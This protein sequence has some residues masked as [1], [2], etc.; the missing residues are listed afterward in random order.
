MDSATAADYSAATPDPV[1]PHAA[2]AIAH[3]NADHADSLA[4]M[5]RVLGG[6]PDATAAVCTGIDR[7]GLDL[8]VSTPRGP[9]AAYT[10]VGFGKAL[11]SADELRSATVELTA[12]ARNS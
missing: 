4:A 7:Y 6:Y 12:Q 9:A 1:R 8:R 2:G 5:A 10:R 3:L 11:D